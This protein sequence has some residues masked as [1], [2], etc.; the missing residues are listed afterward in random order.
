MKELVEE[1]MGMDLKD[2][3][4][5]VYQKLWNFT[6]SLDGKEG[7]IFVFVESISSRRRGRLSSLLPFILFSGVSPHSSFH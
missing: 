1:S 2:R 7:E 5:E 4:E 6:I 3:L